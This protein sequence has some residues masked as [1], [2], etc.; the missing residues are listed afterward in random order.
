MVSIPARCDACGYEFRPPFVEVAGG[1]TVVIGEGCSTPCP[2]C[3]GIARFPEGQFT[4]ENNKLRVLNASDVTREMLV[5]LSLLL[6]EAAQNPDNLRSIQ[7]RAEAIHSG[8]GSLFAPASWSPEI[9]GAL[10]GAITTLL[11]TQCS[12]P[13]TVNIS[14]YTTIQIPESRKVRP[15][16]PSDFGSLP[17]VFRK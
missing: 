12:A 13:T 1:G 3:G 2:R 15:S 17:I 8:F 9:K 4:E 16:H 7:E 11:A 5:R 14:N 6:E 10:I